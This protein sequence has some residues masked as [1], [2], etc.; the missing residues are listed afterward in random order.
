MKE[1]L[2]DEL[3]SLELLEESQ[4]LDLD[5]FQRKMEVQKRILEILGEEELYWC[6]RAHSTWLLKGDNNSDFFHRIAN[7]RKRKH[8]IISFVDGNDRIEGESNL[9]NH[10]TDFYKNLFG[11]A[12]GNALPLNEDLWEHNEKVT[13]DDNVELIKPF[14]EIEIKEALFQMEIKQ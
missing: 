12:P 10:A 6:R 14:S 9:I 11:P 2:Q 7:G 1:A 8:T 4:D 3:L 5:Q 13:E